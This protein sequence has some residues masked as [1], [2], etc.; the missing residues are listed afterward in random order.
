VSL[1]VR[2]KQDEAP[3]S[4]TVILADTPVE[5]REAKQEPEV[6]A[7]FPLPEKK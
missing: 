5:E 2:K 4:L 6:Q 1:E 3:V 7:T